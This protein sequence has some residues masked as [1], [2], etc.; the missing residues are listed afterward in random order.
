MW[1]WRSTESSSF[2]MTWFLSWHLV[3]IVGQV[4]VFLEYIQLIQFA[5][6]GFKTSSSRKGCMATAKGLNIFVKEKLQ[7]VIFNKFVQNSQINL[8]KNM[9]SLG[10]C[11]LSA[12]RLIEWQLC[13]CKVNWSVL[14][15][16]LILNY[17]KCCEHVMCH[18]GVREWIVRRAGDPCVLTEAK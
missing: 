2:S 10:H 6:V 18:E 4:C 1:L 17:V 16:F 14:Y 13:G 9:F 3:W 15:R 12:C 7:C 11:R 5:A 8:S